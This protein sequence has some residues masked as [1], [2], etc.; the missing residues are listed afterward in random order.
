MLTEERR[1]WIEIQFYNYC[2]LI[3]RVRNKPMDVIK[4][5]EQFCNMLKL[6]FNEVKKIIL[7]ILNDPYYT[8]TSQEEIVVAIKNGCKTLDIAK[9][10]GITQQ[11]V[12][13][14]KREYSEKIIPTPKLDLDQDIMLDRIMK[15]IFDIERGIICN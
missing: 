10:M 6:D 3:F 15:L 8:P 4:I 5:M 11:W 2:C 13:K 7:T 9:T 12:N 14:V 1:R